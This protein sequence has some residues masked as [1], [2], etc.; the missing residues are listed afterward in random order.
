MPPSPDLSALINLPSAAL[1]PTPA[2]FLQDSP[3]STWP[4]LQT[5]HHLSTLGYL[6]TGLLLPPLPKTVL[7]LLSL[8]QLRPITS[9]T[10]TA[11][12]VTYN[13]WYPLFLPHFSLHH[14]SLACWLS[15]VIHLNHGSDKYSEGQ[16]SWTL[17]L[18]SC[19]MLSKSL[20]QCGPQSSHLQNG[21]GICENEDLMK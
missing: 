15:K 10:W 14:A 13:H 3:G 5:L 11:N 21:A 2:G 7:V 8:S 20:N 6:L 9:C 1:D 19:I 12:T 18:S 17:P 4:G 16:I